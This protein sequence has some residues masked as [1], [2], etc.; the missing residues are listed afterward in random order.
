[1]KRFC[2]VLLA[3]A[4][5][6]SAVPA[7]AFENKF[8][9]YWRTRAYTQQDFTGN[10]S[11]TKDLSQ[12]DTRTRLYYTAEFSDKFKFVNKFEMDAV[13]GDGSSYGDIGADG[14][15][16]E[17]KNTYADFT[18]VDNLNFKIGT[19]GIQLCR[20]MLIDD[21]FSG[22]VI[23]YDMKPVK[24][25][26]IWMKYNEGGVGKDA[27]DGDM[28]A[29]ILSP[30]I[31]LGSGITINPLVA[32]MTQEAKPVTGEKTDLYYTALNADM[33]SDLLKAWFTGIYQGGTIE[34]LVGADEDVSAFALILGAD[35]KLGVAGVHGQAFYTSGSSADDTDIETYF[36]PAGSTFY[37]SEIMGAGMFD[38]QWTSGTGGYN[39]VNAGKGVVEGVTAIN[40]GANFKPMDKLTL[41]A[42]LWYAML[43]E[44]RVIG[45]DSN[46]RD[47]EEKDLGFEVNL[48]ANYK[49]FENLDLDV[50]A[51]YLFAGDAFGDDAEDPIEVGTQLSLK[52]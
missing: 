7:M 29:Y 41:G 35:V 8:G 17:V 18:P 33:K 11:E 26:F 19:Q 4:V 15:N 3:S 49:V 52:F 46:G 40:V 42:D 12:V 16:V 10:D 43:S 28:D 20:G 51:A 6:A 44:D 13:W 2:S 36:V 37:W 1:M 47:I 22:A 9:G 50:V 48:K 34:P 14:I 31:G 39:L 5:V 23:T 25:P 45:V 21:D 38:N 32:Y 30:E 27:N 24:I